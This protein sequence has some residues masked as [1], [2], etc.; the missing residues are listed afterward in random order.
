MTLASAFG[1]RWVVPRL[2]AFVARHPE[3]RLELAFEDRFVDLVEAGFDLALRVRDPGTPGLVARRLGTTRFVACAAPAYLARAGTPSSPAEL[4]RHD[5]LVLA[6]YAPRDRW[7][8]TGR[9]GE[10]SVRVAARVL[11]DDAEALRIAA[12]SGLGVALLPDYLV[13]DE[14]ASGALVDVLPRHRAG[15]LGIFAVH[16]TRRQMPRRVRAFADFLAE[17]LGGRRQ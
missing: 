4:A 8:F 13:G 2:P 5:A 9:G 14:L 17:S 1:R 7:T 12:V 16:P 6:V 3:I 11:A 15:S 10:T